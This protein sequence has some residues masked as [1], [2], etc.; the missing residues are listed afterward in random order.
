MTTTTREL[1]AAIDRLPESEK[2][3]IAAEIL[4]RTADQELTSLDDE[5]MTLAADAL[6][7]ELDSREEADALPETR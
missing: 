5:E 3:V 4:R 6:F 2:N 7:L 1:L